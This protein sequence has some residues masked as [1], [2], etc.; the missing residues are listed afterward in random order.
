MLVHYDITTL[1]HYGITALPH[2]ARRGRCSRRAA[3]C[4]ARRHGGV[5]VL[6]MHGSRGIYYSNYDADTLNDFHQRL[7]TPP[8]KRRALV[9]LRQHNSTRH[10]VPHALWLQD[11]SSHRRDGGL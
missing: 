7:S 3:G 4:C 1:R 9:H 6:E 10:A 8:A 5:A 11:A 2:C